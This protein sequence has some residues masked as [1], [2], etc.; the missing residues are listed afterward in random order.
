[1]TT[2]IESKLAS[3]AEAAEAA[4][5]GTQRLDREVTGLKSD[6]TRTTQRVDQL[7]TGTDRLD[8]IA[9]GA[10]DEIAKL[11]TALDA[12][13]RDTAKPADVAAA[14]APAAT[15]L[16]KLESSVSEVLKAEADRQRNAE[17]I[18]LSLE[19]GNLK[20]AMDRG[21]S[22]AA[23]LAEVRKVAGNRLDL[24]TL[25][26]Y[27]SDGVPTLAELTRQ[28]RPLTSAIIDADADQK[29]AS[30]VDRLLSGAK[31]IVRVRKLTPDAG[32]RLGRGD[33]CP[34][35]DGAARRP[36]RRRALD[37]Q[38]AA[39]QDHHAG[40]ADVARKG[41]GA[42]GR[43]DGDGGNRP[44]AQIVARR[45]AASGPR[46]DQGRQAMIRLVLYLV[47][48]GLLA[49]GLAWLADR[50]G[51]MLLNWQGYEIET[52][53]FR[54][55]VIFAFAIG[56]AVFLWSLVRQ[57]WTSPAAVGRVMNRR[58]QERGL[59]ALSS[60]MIAIGAGDRSQAMRYAMQARKAL[61]NE[62]LTHLLR[63]QAAQLSGDRSTSRRI[64]EAMLGSP[65]TE[66]LGLR[67]LFLEAEREGEHE[68]ARQ[69][70][71]RALRL[72]PKLGWPVDALFELQCKAADW[73][74]ALE[75]LAAG[76]RNGH[77]EKADADRRRA[78]LLTAQAQALE[79]SNADRAHR[80]RHRSAH[81]GA[82]SRARRASPDACSPRAARRAKVARVHRADLAAR[83]R[84]PISPSPMPTPAPATARATASSASS[85]SRGR[86]RIRSRHRSPSQRPR[87]RRTTGRRRARRST[88]LLEGRLSQRVCTLMA[89]IE[90]EQYGNAGRVREWLAR[91]VN[92]PRDPAWTADGVVSDRWAPVSP[93]TG[94]LDAFQWKVPVEQ[95]G[96]HDEELALAKLEELIALGAQ[97]DKVIE[98]KPMKAA[99]VE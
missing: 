55:V 68:A 96:P 32:R 2:E 35:R 60:G 52:S 53:V 63:A 85:T 57:L 81:A 82:R 78:V 54:A 67:G 87:S 11:Q 65:D 97:N 26:R 98:E 71:E 16:G 66:Q 69:F 79:D 89:R 42:P 56:L 30:V 92:A 80:A 37:R 7:K 14:V 49:T 3:T 44:A 70:A 50:P 61:P 72:N 62:P 17:R 13:R 25:Q 34:H 77:F 40:D 20:R 18:V 41:R 84:I 91:A 51:Q 74:G 10:Q 88:P 21:G 90:G 15:R 94:A 1:M 12:I 4:R 45:D 93:V 76:K 38:D 43:R 58:R 8:E 28:F 29:D 48:V 31:T 36:P 22:Y 39:A 47:G 73:A 99:P 75:T 19:L 46:G 9:R 83:R 86:R 33:R 23:E 64:F 5:S 95:S 24:A 59:D 27:Q 6:V